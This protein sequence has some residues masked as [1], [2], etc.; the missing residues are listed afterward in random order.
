MAERGERMMNYFDINALSYSGLKEFAKSPAHFK[1]WLT[2]QDEATEAMKFGSALHAAL[3]E[4]DKLAVQEGGTTWRTKGFK[5]FEAENNEKV[6]VPEDA[7]RIIEL[8]T[9]SLLGNMT[10]KG[11]L[12][13]AEKETELFWED[14]DYS[15][16]CKCKIDMLYVQNDTAIIAD[17]KTT[18]DATP[19]AVAKTI[20]NF[21]Y[22]W[23]ASWYPDAVRQCR[24]IKD[25]RFLWIFVEKKP[26]YSVGLYEPDAEMLDVAHRQIQEL[27][28]D[29]AECLEKDH[30]PSI[31]SQTQT[32]SLPKWATY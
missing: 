15:F 12:S 24:G 7:F 25:V 6:C 19:S 3:L 16:K 31:S 4:P 13:R 2:K 17:I 20:A 18:D 29:Y 14:N 23:Q 9:T 8:M 1:Y 26:P 21:K 28:P 10:V 27:L 32:I 11:M 30:W 22:H 5:D